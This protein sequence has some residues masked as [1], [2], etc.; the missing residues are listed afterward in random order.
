MIQIATFL[1]LEIAKL[2]RRVEPLNIR[3]PDPH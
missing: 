1:D 2:G 3:Q